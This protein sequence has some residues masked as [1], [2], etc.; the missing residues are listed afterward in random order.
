MKTPVLHFVFLALLGSF[1]TP[2][3]VAY[4][5][6]SPADSAHFC[7]V[8]DL[9]EWEREQPLPAAK[10]TAL[11][12]GESRIVR[13]FYFLPNDRPE[14]AAVV[15]DMKT[16]ILEVQSFYRE[17]MAAHGYGNKTFQIETDAQGVPIVH[18]VN[19][20]YSDSHYKDRGR[21]ENEISRAFD[22]SSIVQLVV[23]DISRS[24]GGRGV[25]IK[26]RGQ[27][28]VDG[29]WNWRTAAM[30]SDTPSACNT[31]FAIRHTS[32]RMD[33]VGIPC[34]QAQHSF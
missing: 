31:I 11:N 16:G 12:A 2:L 24:S 28:I 10:R 6:P 14:R 20:D 3:S 30:N 15:E 13:L 25:G 32:C 22:T 1:L 34:L 26:Q 29:G 9:E 5:S 8:I 21:P 23:M 7:Q 4:A 17:Q 27:A 33:P 18:R 19:G